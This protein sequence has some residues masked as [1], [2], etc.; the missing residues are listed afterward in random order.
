MTSLPAFLFKECLFRKKNIM[1]NKTN[2]TFKEINSD[3][4]DSFGTTVKS[5]NTYFLKA[6]A[7]LAGK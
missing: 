4:I 3:Y 1:D 6:L 2:I 5:G 7:F